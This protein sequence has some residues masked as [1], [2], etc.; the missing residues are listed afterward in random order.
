MG[1]FILWAKGPAQ[2]RAGLGILG[3]LW[4]SVWLMLRTEWL[5]GFLNVRKCL[6]LCLRKIR[7]FCIGS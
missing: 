7:G 3:I 6:G 5:L 2:E 1:I 4:F